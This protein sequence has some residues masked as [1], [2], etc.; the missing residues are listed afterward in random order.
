MNV[1]ADSIIDGD[2]NSFWSVNTTGGCPQ[3]TIIAPEAINLTGLKICAHGDNWPTHY[4][5][6][7]LSSDLNWEQLAELKGVSD[8]ESTA[9]FSKSFQSSHFRFTIYGAAATDGT[10][11]MSCP[12]TGNGASSISISSDTDGNAVVSTDQGD[13]TTASVVSSAQAR[14]E[15]KVQIDSSF[16]A[17]VTSKMQ[18]SIS[19]IYP[20]SANDS[21]RLLEK[22]T[23]LSPS[24]SST[25]P[26]RSTSSRF[27][28]SHNS[29]SAS[30]SPSPTST[31]KP[32]ASLTPTPSPA[33]SPVP[34]HP[35]KNDGTW[36][37]LGAV[38]ASCISLI[39]L[40][41]MAFRIRRR[42]LRGQP[43]IWTEYLKRAN[44][45]RVKSSSLPELASEVWRKELGDGSALGSEL[46]GSSPPIAELDATPKKQI[47]GGCKTKK[48]DSWLRS[49][50]ART[51]RRYT[52]M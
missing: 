50:A 35:P 8:H 37:I 28:T 9:V 30:H 52:V 17:T 43:Q 22:N 25:V 1:G 5:V 41:A 27:S 4:K 15:A 44:Y 21:S 49:V 20:I 48:S 3:V 36:L 13:G 2:A 19:E 40:T 23:T 24:S 32:P 42:S 14:A 10:S 33:P 51:L 18:T 38:S 31:L 34:K 16:Q 7:G 29:R 26:P 45:P 39:I 47:G 12:T 46:E 6:E 11:S